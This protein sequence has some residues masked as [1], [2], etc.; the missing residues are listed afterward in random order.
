M[1]D[2]EVLAAAA[3]EPTDRMILKLLTNLRVKHTDR[4][5]DLRADGF[6]TLSEFGS[7]IKAE[8]DQTM[9]HNQGNRGKPKG[10]SR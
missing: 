2:P 9:S 3:H 7:I 10:A 1:K 8:F 5:V 4:S 6:G